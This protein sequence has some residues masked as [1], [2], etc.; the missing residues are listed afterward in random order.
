MDFGW[1]DVFEQRQHMLVLQSTL[2]SVHEGLELPVFQKENVFSSFDHQGLTLF[3]LQLGDE[4]VEA[5][6]R[7]T[8]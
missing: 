3:V 5:R 7:R 6:H 1:G 4:G 8:H 2:A